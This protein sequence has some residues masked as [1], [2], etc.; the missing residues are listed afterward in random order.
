M[1]RARVVIAD[2]QPI[3]RDGLR[4]LVET[5]PDLEVVG[6][7]GDLVRADGLVEDRRADVLLLDFRGDGQAAL[8][9]LRRLA[10][11]SS[12]VRSIILSDALNSSGVATAV[13]LGV[14]GIVLKDSA[15]DV[16]FHAIHTVSSGGC[17]I[18][19]GPVTDAAAAL[20]TRTTSRQRRK[21]F[22]LTTSELEIVRMV[23]AGLTNKQIAE[24]LSIA[25]NTVKSHLTHIF[26]KVG[27]ST[28]V[29]LALFAEHHR[30]LDTI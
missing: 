16:L 27:A 9:L 17:W 29:E 14:G 3:S 30:L 26:N 12:R 7:T 20:R 4:R 1:G 15:S 22:G 21:T 25:E 18:D 10:A 24:R 23:V 13:E 8:D 5:D 11:K 6:D 19:S 2:P 28:R